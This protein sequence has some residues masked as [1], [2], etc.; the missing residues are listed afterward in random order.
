[1]HTCFDEFPAL[2]NVFSWCGLR[3]KRCP[4]VSKTPAKQVPSAPK[5]CPS[6]QMSATPVLQIPMKVPTE[7]CP[8]LFLY[9]FKKGTPSQKTHTF[10]WWARLLE[11]YK[12]CVSATNSKPHGSRTLQRDVIRCCS[13]PLRLLISWRLGGMRSLRACLEWGSLGLR[14]LGGRVKGGLSG[15]RYKLWGLRAPV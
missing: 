9:N 3:A 8:K 4:S 10:S 1:M 11:F 2:C 13:H 15:M 7:R 12:G 14:L 5:I 6:A